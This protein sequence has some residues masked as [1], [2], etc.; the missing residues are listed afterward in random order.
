MEMTK[1]ADDKIQQL[2]LLEQNVQHLFMQKQ[3]FQT[4][5]LEME[6]AAKELETSKSSYKI[7]GNILVS[8]DPKKLLAEAKEK[9]ETI[10]LRISTIEK[11]ESKLKE[12]IKNLQADVLV[13]MKE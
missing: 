4:Q 9:L 7:I 6:S 13:G 11:Q 1:G 5:L 12:R 3:Q 10:N 2:Q 8:S